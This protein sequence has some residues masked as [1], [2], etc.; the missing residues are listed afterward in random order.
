M[1]ELRFV[2]ITTESE[3]EALDLGRRIVDARL[4]A[5]VN[6]LPAIKSVYRWKNKI[7]EGAEAALIVKTRA[8]CLPALTAKVREWHSYETPCIV[9]LPLAPDEGNPDYLEWIGNESA[10]HVD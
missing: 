3:A 10:A 6:V 9:A 7:E 1:S 4:A 5:C 8:D 2:Y